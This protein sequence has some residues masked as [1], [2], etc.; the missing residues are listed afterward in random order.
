MTQ[1]CSVSTPRT[2]RTTTGSN[3]LIK[4]PVIWGVGCQTLAEPGC[5]DRDCTER[6]PAME[7]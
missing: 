5:E 4:V 3:E 6:L 7:G 2:N 1:P